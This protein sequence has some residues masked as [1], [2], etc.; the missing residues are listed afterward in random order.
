MA[1]Q[2]LPVYL[3]PEQHHAL[4]QLSARTGRSM[5]ELVRDM[6]Q[7][8]LF[9]D[10]PPTDLSDLAGAVNLGHPTD[11]SRDRDDLLVDAVRVVR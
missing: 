9:G 1:R 3:T 6:L 4:Q 7:T 2:S 8:Y 5:S 11:I 10:E